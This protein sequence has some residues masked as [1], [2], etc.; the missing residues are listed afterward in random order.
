[1]VLLI[2]GRGADTQMDRRHIDNAKED[3]HG[4]GCRGVDRYLK[5][6]RGGNQPDGSAICRE[7]QVAPIFLQRVI[8]GF[9]QCRKKSFSGR[10]AAN[11]LQVAC[12]RALQGG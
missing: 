6:E 5:C 2:V 4:D 12:E 10:L 1:M 11:I 3:R 8:H 7:L 9:P